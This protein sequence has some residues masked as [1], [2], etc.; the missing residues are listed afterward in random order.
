M[1][2]IDGQEPRGAKAHA[3]TVAPVIGVRSEASSR[4]AA[5]PAICAECE[6]QAAAY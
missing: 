1:S 5:G 4:S 6:H 2:I 3:P